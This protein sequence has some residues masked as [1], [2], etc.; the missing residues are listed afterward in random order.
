MVKLLMVVFAFSS[1]SLY[2]FDNKCVYSSGYQWVKLSKGKFD[3]EVESIKSPWVKDCAQDILV[4][5]RMTPEQEDV[6]RLTRLG[7]FK[8]MDLE[9]KPQS[10]EGCVY[11]SVSGRIIYC[12][13]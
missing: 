4:K 6:F 3:V 7:K 2:S 8:F 13:K 1:M 11:R 5:D 10:I 12:R 9:K